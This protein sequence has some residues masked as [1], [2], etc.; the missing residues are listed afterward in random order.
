M[1]IR[2]YLIAGSFLLL[3]GCDDNN[4]APL[5]PNVIV[6]DQ[7]NLTNIQYNRLR[8]D[9]GY[10]YL[11]AGVRGIIV[12]RENANRYRAI[13]RN[14]SYKPEDACGIVEVDASN[15]FLKDPCCGSQFDL[16]GQVTGGP[17]TYP[18]RQYGTTL[19]GNFLYITN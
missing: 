6:N 9:N 16:T 12:I 5:I 4:A 2:N 17:A 15:L 1:T 18:L 3:A 19:Q 13:E 11:N 10:V 7:L 14:C 8:Q